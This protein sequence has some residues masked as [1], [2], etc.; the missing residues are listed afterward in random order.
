MNPL[1]VNS[2]VRVKKNTFQN[3]KRNS[4]RRENLFTF[5]QIFLMPGLTEDSWALMAPS[6]GSLWQH[7]DSVEAEKKTTSQEKCSWKWWGHFN[8]VSR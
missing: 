7:A 1:H 5:L 2:L 6:A 8:G 4:V 3:K